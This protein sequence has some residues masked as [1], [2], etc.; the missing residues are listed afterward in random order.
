MAIGTRQRV[1]LYVKPDDSGTVFFGETHRVPGLMSVGY[2]VSAR[3][4]KYRLSHLRFVS[5]IPIESEATLDFTCVLTGDNLAVWGLLVEAVDQTNVIGIPV[6]GQRYDYELVY[7]VLGQPDCVSFV[8]RGALT[9]NLAINANLPGVVQLNMTLSG[10]HTVYV[11]RGAST[12]H[13]Y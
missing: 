5:S 4:G 2:S 13:G 3:Q 12:L 6:L 7:G 10:G 1:A 9:T 8:S 11:Y